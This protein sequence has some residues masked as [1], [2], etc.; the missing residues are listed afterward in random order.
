V[1]TNVRFARPTSR[2]EEVVAFYVDG[3]GLERIGSFVGHDGYDGVMVGAPGDEAH[4][5]FTRHGE[6]GPFPSP[7]RDNLVVLYF[8]DPAEVEE[9]V[10][11]LRAAGHEPVEPENP[12]WRRDGTTFEDPDGWRVVLMRRRWER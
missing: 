12:Y 9:R 7:G 11:R 2:L 4:L 8:D 1:L 5:E 10:A 3:L 6:D